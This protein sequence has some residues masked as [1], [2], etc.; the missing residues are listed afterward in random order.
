MRPPY[1]PATIIEEQGS[2]WAIVEDSET[3]TISLLAMIAL[4]VIATI[5]IATN[6][7]NTNAAND[8]D[9]DGYAD[10]WTE[11]Y[12]GSNAQGVQLDSCPT[13]WGNSTR[14]NLT[15]Y[16]Y[17]CPDSDGD[18]YTN[19]YVYDVDQETG[20]RINELGDAFPDEP[21]QSKDND[22]DG[23]GDNPIGVNGDLCPTVPGVAEGTNGPGCRVIDV[24]DDDGDGVIN[25]L[26]T[27]CPNS[28]P[29]QTVNQD[30]CCLL[31]TSPSPR[32]S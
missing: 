17:G 31:Y 18:G 1:T 23:F 6:I 24:N 2:N 10:N 13:E 22:G 30:G 8:T 9:Q 29:G 7:A 3:A 11:Y 27:L 15:V 28:P 14:R 25:E 5:A 19:T 16:A 32:D 4:C 12:N 26:D 20:L 21:S